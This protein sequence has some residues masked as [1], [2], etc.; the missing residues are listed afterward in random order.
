MRLNPKQ[1]TFFI[2]SKTSIQFH[3]VIHDFPASSCLLAFLA[4]FNYPPMIG[5]TAFSDFSIVPPTIP[6]A[7]IPSTSTHFLFKEDMTRTF[8]S[9]LQNFVLNAIVHFLQSIYVDH[10][11]DELVRKAVD[12]K[13]E[14]LPV[15]QLRQRA[16]L[17]LIN[18][19]E[20]IDGMEQLPTNVIGVGGLQIQQPKQ[21]SMVWR[22]LMKTIIFVCCN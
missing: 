18:Y 4:K 20:I 2:N 10:A 6:S 11:M 12:G 15:K 19:N 14:V 13:Y 17:A 3:L 16:T 5:M 22:Q 8:F 1:F 9:R 7:L 21:L